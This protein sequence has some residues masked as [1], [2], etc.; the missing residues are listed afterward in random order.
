MSYS[1]HTVKLTRSL[2]RAWILD[3]KKCTE[4]S[5]GHSDNCQHLEFEPSSCRVSC[6][7]PARNSLVSRRL[8]YLWLTSM[9]SEYFQRET[10]LLCI[11]TNLASSFATVA[12]A[13]WTVNAVTSIQTAGITL[14][15]PTELCPAKYGH[16]IT[17]SGTSLTVTN[18]NVGPGF[19]SRRCCS[20]HLRFFLAMVGGVCRSVTLYGLCRLISKI[21]LQIRMQGIRSATAE[22]APLSFPSW[23]AR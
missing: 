19:F 16:S 4:D 7:V 13:F 11:S 10:V 9:T 1:R 22:S 2:I 23:M 8:M 20:I 14:M 18:R 3:L 21:Q 5:L 6:K 12:V 17:G 15:E